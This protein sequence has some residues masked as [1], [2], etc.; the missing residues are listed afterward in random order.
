[1]LVLHG[2]VT[3]GLLHLWG[4]VPDGEAVSGRRARDAG[5]AGPLLPHPF[6][7]SF[8]Q[9][10]EG[11]QPLLPYGAGSEAPL[12]GGEWAAWLPAM[13]GRPVPSSPLV[14]GGVEPEPGGPVRLR[15]FRV[16]ALTMPPSALLAV[17]GACDH[18]P[19]APGVM[20]APDLAYWAAVLR[21]AASIVGRQAFL[22]DLVATP[23]GYVP[24]WRPLYLGRD[25]AHL[26]A[27]ARSMPPAA[28]SLRPL[29]SAPAPHGS[30][31]AGKPE[32]D[33]LRCLTAFLDRVVDALVRSGMPEGTARPV[34]SGATVHERWVAGLGRAVGPIQGTDDEL[35]R[36]ARQVADW[37]GPLAALSSSPYRLCLRLE[38]EPGHD[39]EDGRGLTDD[40]LDEMMEP[41]WGGGDQ[42]A[43]RSNGNAG[44]GDGK[45]PWFLRFLLQDRSDP[46]LL[47][48][49]PD[50]WRAA[51]DYVLLAL[52][53]AG[54]V[55]PPIGDS[56]KKGGIPAGCPLDTE[57]AYAFLAQAAPALE[58]ADFGLFL[59]AWWTGRAG[60]L[61]LRARARSASSQHGFTGGATGALRLDQLV[62]VD[63]EIVLGDETVTPQQ[64]E[65]LARLKSPLVRLRGRWVQV[66]PAAL[67]AALEFVGRGGVTRM[68]ARDVLAM[69]LGSG[70]GTPATGE[71][72]AAAALPLESVR[73]TGWLGDLLDALQEGVRWRELPVPRGLRAAL[74]PYQVRGYSWLQFL[75]GWGLGACLADD[76]GL[77]K[78]IQTLTA[79]AADREAGER[80]PVLLVCPTSVL[81]NWEQEAARF[82]PGLTVL[83]HHGPERART[84]AAFRRAVSRCHLV[85]TS[86]GLMARDQPLLQG[87]EW[88]GVV[89]DEAQ[90][91]K[92][93]DTAQARAA[94]S[95]NAGYRIALTGTPVEN[96]VGD[97]WS[98]MEF[99]N[100]GFLGSRTEFQRRFL[101]PIRSHGDEEALRRLRRLTGPFIL[102]RLKTDPSI[103]SDLPDKIETTVFA[104]LT[105]EQASLYAAV[106]QEVEGALDEAEGM[107]RRGLILSL[108]TRLKQ[109]C[110]HPAQ[111]LGDGSPLPGRSG[112][113]N[114][115]TE[116]V[117]E[118][119][120]ADGRALIFTQFA[121]MGELIQRHLQ[122][123]FGREVLFL[124]GGVPRRTR[125]LMV[126]RFQE[127][128]DGP[129]LFVL[130]L[131]AGG[132]GLNLT[133]AHHVF[134]Y[135]RWWNPAVE[136]QAVDR[137]FRIGQVRN[138]HVHKFVCRGTLEEAIDRLIQSKREMAEKVV[139]TG[140]GW[141]TELST[142]ELRALVAL[143]QEAVDE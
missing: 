118:V 88:A 52:T 65:Q 10:R 97:L 110:N 121:A 108:L 82:T 115:L 87:V 56:L 78:T 68:A 116:L 2:A 27:L 70:E 98:I 13:K 44:G 94:R 103:I 25:Q 123:T 105:R 7:A 31:G 127:E 5:G 104:S 72:A 117:E 130:S 54:K 99:L 49:L 100:P 28:R 58:E 51:P 102:R 107:A 93:P 1:M 67:Q 83:V 86:Y 30:A 42:E 74:R 122:D 47:L 143:R 48:P 29:E 39:T 124:H 81:G 90:N 89:L 138:V 62:D 32:G 46:S 128:K 134:L 92:N 40:G 113:L 4:E 45:G 26:T 142:D 109:V 23:E 76:M 33:A 18:R 137:A 114:R 141:L 55:F 60:R 85:V 125:E 16:P 21:F 50:A 15:A 63:W 11:L 12:P 79:I 80:R 57:G 112:K 132:T 59:P 131:K 53:E 119:L 136:S 66:D 38:E 14:R 139:G 133:R 37:H 71:G 20:A 6:A 9:L 61:A 101:I 17:L 69:A 95:L 73:A 111:F 120:D 96:H 129:P 35:A 64:L 43:A 41:V 3:D 22:P 77:G 19:L 34:R 126:R 36:L 8:Q 91:I 84:K 140:E 135:D 24:C 75:K 106:L